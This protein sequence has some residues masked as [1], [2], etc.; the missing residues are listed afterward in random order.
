MTPSWRDA[1]H[2]TVTAALAPFVSPFLDDGGT[3]SELRDHVRHEA[4]GGDRRVLPVV[5]GARAY[6][7]TRAALTHGDDAVEPEV[8]D[9]EPNWVPRL[10][11][12]AGP[13]GEI[14]EAAG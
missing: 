13:F 10:V 11:P 5:L 12:G 8:M 9:D 7:V 4:R 3:D 1:A 6:A 2:V 14:E